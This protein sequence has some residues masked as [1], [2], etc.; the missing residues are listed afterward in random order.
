MDL[1]GL[2]GGQKKIMYV[3]CLV[4]LLVVWKNTS[5]NSNYYYYNTR[6]ADAEKVRARV[7]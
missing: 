4:Q 3:K 6:N 1:L 2:P 7:A 5:T